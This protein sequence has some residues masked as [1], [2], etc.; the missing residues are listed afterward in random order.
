MIRK[1]EHF[2]QFTF[3]VDDNA[4]QK[5]LEQ[6]AYDEVITKLLES[7]KDSLPKK[8]VG[9][10]ADKQIDWS[11][12]INKAF[13]DFMEEHKDEIIQAAVEKITKSVKNSKKYRNKLEEVFADE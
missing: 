13:Y 2:V 11:F 8:Y 6:N 12:A 4:I 10:K 9:Y 5:K 7:A 3:S 1:M